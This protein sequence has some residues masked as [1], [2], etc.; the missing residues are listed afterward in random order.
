MEGFPCGLGTFLMKSQSPP[1]KRTAAFTL[2]ELLVVIAIIAILA[3]ILF[4]VFAQAKLAA[5]KTA[6]LSN[7]KQQGLAMQMYA[8]DNE[9]GYPTWSEAFGVSTNNTT[10]TGPLYGVPTPPDT[11]STYWDA[12]LSPYVK[13]GKPE[14]GDYSGMWH[15]PGGDQPLNKRSYGISY[16]FTYARDPAS[17]WS[18][19]WLNQNQIVSPATLVM[20]GESGTAGMMSRQINYDGYVQK[21]ITPT[22]FT[23]EVP[24]RFGNGAGYSYAD[25]HAKFVVRPKYWAW[26]TPPAT[27]YSAY[28]G[29]NY[30]IAANNFAPASS[31]MVALQNQAIAAGYN[32]VLQNN[33]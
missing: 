18:Y 28:N 33:N 31:E 24:E 23:R 3:A 14:T 6:S 10:T 15:S 30:C 21:Y 8:G 22:V 19:R 32:C 17:P 2:I 9:D 25:G 4:P 12:K 11:V 29:L 5:K 13:S 20:T 7:V 1:T 26:P 16:Y 27:N